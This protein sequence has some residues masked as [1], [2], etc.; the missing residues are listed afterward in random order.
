MLKKKIEKK[1]KKTLVNV[2]GRVRLLGLLEIHE[3]NTVFI[4]FHN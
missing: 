1:K 2:V 3:N 4:C